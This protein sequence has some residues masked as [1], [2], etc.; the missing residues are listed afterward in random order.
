MAGEERHLLLLK[1][2]VGGHHSSYIVA[3]QRSEKKY[4][5]I[6]SLVGA[7]LRIVDCYDI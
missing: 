6:D 7:I 5:L 3:T 2:N 4:N 1:E